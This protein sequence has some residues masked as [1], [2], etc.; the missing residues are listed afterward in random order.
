MLLLSHAAAT[1]AL[2]GLIWFV[3][4]CHYPLFALV[5]PDTFSAYEAAYTRSTTW[6]IVPL[7]LAE[8]G[9]TVALLLA[10][11]PP[12]LRVLAWVGAGLLALIWLS[13]FAVQ[14]PLHN[15]LMNGFDPAAHARLVSSNWIRTAAWTARGAVALA[16]L[17]ITRAA[18]ASNL[19]DVNESG[20]RPSHRHA[21]IADHP[22]KA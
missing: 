6:V 16:M 8:L 7:M 14:V 17:W 15:R 18:P 4:V 1:F 22:T 11:A 9:M 12:R 10:P 2:V 3:Q 13:T 19:F 5:G 20:L 21:L